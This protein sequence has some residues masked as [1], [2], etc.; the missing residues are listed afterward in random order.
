MQKILHQ[1]LRQI[2]HK[3]S[4]QIVCLDTTLTVTIHIFFFFYLNLTLFCCNLRIFFGLIC[5]C[6]NLSDVKIFFFLSVC[7]CVLL[8]TLMYNYVLLCYFIYFNVVLCTFKFLVFFN[9]QYFPSWL[10]YPIWYFCIIVTTQQ[11]FLNA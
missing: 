7:S 11:I 2:D 5:F 4:H 8:C 6:W 10:E 9:F 3:M 1:I